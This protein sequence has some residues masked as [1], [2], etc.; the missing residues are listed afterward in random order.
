MGIG[1]GLARSF[2]F[3]PQMQAQNKKITQSRQNV[4]SMQTADIIK[5]MTKEQLEKKK[6]ALQNYYVPYDASFLEQGFEVDVFTTERGRKTQLALKYSVNEQPQTIVLANGNTGKLN[7]DA[8][9]KQLNKFFSIELKKYATLDGLEPERYI[10]YIQEMGWKVT[11]EGLDVFS[12]TRSDY[13][14]EIK[15][16]EFTN[17]ELENLKSED[18]EQNGKEHRLRR[19]W[20]IIH[21]ISEYIKDGYKQVSFED[22]KKLGIGSK[23]AGNLKQKYQEV[24]QYEKCEDTDNRLS[25]IF[26]TF[27][28]MSLSTNSIQDEVNNY[29]Q[30]I[31]EY[32]R[33]IPPK[34]QDENQ[35]EYIYHYLVIRAEAMQQRRVEEKTPSE[36]VKLN[37]YIDIIDERDED[38]KQKTRLQMKNKV[39]ELINMHNQQE[40]NL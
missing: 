40:I 31:R 30:P 34:Y 23:E 35:Y 27:R 7:I 19:E 36:N 39:Q 38:R 26:A 17:Q 37:K 8:T 14:V 22:I 4:E 21:S 11:P 33:Q 25:Q 9:K 29:I 6:Q 10:E 12:R 15:R 32:I 20:Q 28:P 18:I 16:T 24:I 5:M 3:K 2:G 1:A 13:E